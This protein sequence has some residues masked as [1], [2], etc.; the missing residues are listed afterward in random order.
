MGYLA[1]YAYELA[2]TAIPAFIG[3]FLLYNEM[4]LAKILFGF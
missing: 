3:R 1:P 2:C 4:G